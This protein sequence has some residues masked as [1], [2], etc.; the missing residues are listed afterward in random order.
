MSP[1]Y[2][3]VHQSP[4]GPGDARPTAHQII[5]DQHLENQ[6]DGK[7]ILITGCSSGLGVETAHALYRTGATLYLTARDIDK[8]RVALADIA[9]SPR[10]HFLHLDLSSLKSVRA[11]ADAFQA[12]SQTLHVLIQNAAVMACSEGRTP[13]GF[14]T[15]F[16]TNHLGHFLLFHL[17]KP[18]L[19]GSSTALFNSRVVIVSSIAHQYSAVNF[20]NFNLDG[21]YDAWKA[22]GQSKTANIWTA[23]EIDRRYGAWGLH[24]WSLHPGAIATNL[25][26][27]VPEEQKRLWIQD[28]D[29]QKHW[30]SP[31]QGA[32][33]TV[34]A[35]V[36]TQLE[37][38][39]GKYLEDCA[40]VRGAA[41]GQGSSLAAWT[42]DPV[43]ETKL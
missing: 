43:S 17:L 26:R 30:K 1:D 6:W 11:C 29:A 12:T 3:Q 19:L 35:A 15:Q 24:A 31:E 42:Y 18:V 7:T 36:S 5:K 32:A 39:G 41:N 2:T 4:S 21:E 37:G 22:Y 14:E 38:L 34:W 23:N 9:S 20:D 25:Q 28:A 40:I 13:D 16:G 27:H 33:T 8:A 10:V